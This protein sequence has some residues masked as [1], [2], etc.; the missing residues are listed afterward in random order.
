MKVEK[1][2]SGSC[3]LSPTNRLLRNWTLLAGPR[4]QSLA[5]EG[6]LIDQNAAGSVDQL[7][8]A[9]RGAAEG[10]IAIE[11]QRAAKDRLGA[12]G[13]AGRIDAAVVEDANVLRTAIGLDA[14]VGHVVDI[15]V[16]DIDG[17]GIPVGVAAGRAI[18][19]DVDAVMPVGD[20]V[21][22]HHM[23]LPVHLDRVF[24]GNGGG[25]AREFRP[26]LRAV[27]PGQQFGGDRG[28]R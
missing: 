14:I 11:V 26:H 13:A 27:I 1:L 6:V 10:E 12:E 25:V 8:R 24:R 4:Q 16:I 19:R 9:A 5:N 17:A 18:G 2:N 15:V 23:A 3:Q 21:V 22:G 20:I 28:G 7:E